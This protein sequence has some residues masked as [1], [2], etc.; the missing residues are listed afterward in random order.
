M[1]EREIKMARNFNNSLEYYNCKK[2]NINFSERMAEKTNTTTA[3]INA[4]EFIKTIPVND[5]LPLELFFHKDILK[6]Y[7]ILQIIDDEIYKETF[8]TNSDDNGDFF[9]KLHHDIFENNIVINA[10]KELFKCEE[11]LL[12][13]VF[14]K[15]GDSQFQERIINI[16]EQIQEIANLK[17]SNKKAKNKLKEICVELSNIVNGT[18][19]AI[20]KYYE[21]KFNIVFLTDVSVT[22]D[23][24]YEEFLFNYKTFYEKVEEE[25]KRI[26]TLKSNLKQEVVEYIVNPSRFE[27]YKKRTNTINENIGKKWKELDDS[28]KRELVKRNLKDVIIPDDIFDI[29]V[30][31]NK[32][33][34][35]KW[36]IKKGFINGY[37]NIEINNENVMELIDI[38]KPVKK[39][40]SIKTII[41]ED[42]IKQIN[43][44]TLKQIVTFIEVNEYTKEDLIGDEKEYLKKIKTLL[45]VKRFNKNDNMY[46]IENYKKMVNAIFDL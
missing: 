35:V 32:G 10:E 16:E 14:N 7:G 33:A 37:K 43:E 30:N 17:H 5:K 8:L 12:E 29:L 19:L 31:D 45:D 9:R 25:R 13:Y 40:T 21:I 42:L 27:L 1:T 18:K 46:I 4:I 39:Q 38:P 28:V 3:Y 41:T 23:S 20:D 34:Y 11:Q 36:S 24:V 2:R 26:S 44:Y 15:I 22:I 6:K